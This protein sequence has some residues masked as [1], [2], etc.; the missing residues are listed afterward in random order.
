MTLET[1]TGI[2]ALAGLQYKMV[3][4]FGEAMNAA[5]GFDMFTKQTG[6]SWQEL[7]KWQIV[8]QQAHVSAESVTASVTALQKQM[9]QIKLGQGNFA[10][11][12]M[13]GIGVN[14]NAFD[15]LKQIRE[16]IRGMD[17]ATAGN[18][19]EQMGLTPDMLNVLELSNVEFD[20][21][22]KTMAGMSDTQEKAFLRSKDTMIK[23][24]MVLKYDAFEA[25]SN[26]VMGLE[27]FGKY[28]N[29]V[30][31]DMKL[32]IASVG[33][34]AAAFYPVFAVITALL[35]LFEDLAVYF[36]GGKSLTGVAI[37]GLK[38]FGQELKAAFT[39]PSIGSIASAGVSN[40]TGGM[41]N[42]AQ[43]GALAQTKTMQNVF[44]VSV[45]GAGPAEA[46]AQEVTRQIVRH[47]GKAE[48]ELNNQGH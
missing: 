39:I 16:K 47:F 38:K 48:Q 3:Q 25:L 19:I 8:A 1:A 7:Q 28:I 27:K 17:R 10:P 4:L 6:L 14:G 13:L 41:I 34:L 5:V 2:I 21:L 42:P 35:L 9:A 24:S 20:R 15:T 11:F 36:S 22:S 32:L 46:I 26:F 29:S 43:L 44:N 30:A 31:G 37:E 33:L 40:L 45:T 18:I 23:W 12:Q